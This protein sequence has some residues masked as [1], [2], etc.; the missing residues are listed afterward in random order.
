[1]KNNRALSILFTTFLGFTLIACGSKEP[2]NQSDSQGDQAISGIDGRD[3]NDGI[4]GKD[5]NTILTGNGATS[6]NIGND[7]D[8][9]I[10]LNSWDFYVK[11]SGIWIK[12]G[13]IKGDDGQD[14]I[15]LQ[16]KWFFDSTNHW[17]LDVQTSSIVKD[18]SSHT[19]VEKVYCPTYLRNGFTEHK[20]SIC[21]YVYQDNITNKL[22]PTEEWKNAHGVFKQ[23]ISGGFTY[24]LYPQT[25]VNNSELISA[26]NALDTSNKDLNNYYFYNNEYYAKLDVGE[27]G[28]NRRFNNDEVILSNHT[29]WFLAEPI[30]WET[31]G[32]N[33][34]NSKK[35]LNVRD[36]DQSDYIYLYSG[37]R[38]WLNNDF[39]ISAFALDDSKLQVIEVDNSAE[40]MN[41]YSSDKTSYFR[42]TENSFD[43]VHLLCKREYRNEYGITAYGE[44]TAGFSARK[45]IAT[46]YTRA[47]GGY[48]NY[49]S[50]ISGASIRGFFWTRFGEIIDSGGDWYSES[51]SYH[52]G[53]LK[54]HMCVRPCISFI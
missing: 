13:N 21:G 19:F 17:H 49:S 1:M 42:C 43:K 39:Y 44:S 33:K 24:G 22:Q 45:S 12:K 50:S 34:F 29:Y 11:T 2:S 7:S 54:K 6:N 26:L 23:A 30:E 20:C 48:C 53:E 9:Y 36:F 27:I 52:Y 25:V 5:G 14:Y 46:D 35:L 51:S 47:L 31:V 40:A 16:D 8:I 32:N 3:G 41:I 37:I 15:E 4:N 18:M 38:N 28:S 10:D